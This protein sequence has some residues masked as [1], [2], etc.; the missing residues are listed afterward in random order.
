MI[1]FN[2]VTLDVGTATI[3]FTG[4]AG[5]FTGE[6]GRFTGNV[7]LPLLNKIPNKLLKIIQ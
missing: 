1:Y 5:R 4:E 6:A 3:R 7:F 2:L